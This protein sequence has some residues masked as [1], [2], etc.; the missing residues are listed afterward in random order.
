MPH[1]EGS[2]LKTVPTPHRHQSQ[3]QAS[4]T[5]EL[6]AASSQPTLWVWLIC[7]S[8]LQNREKLRFTSWLWKIITE[9][10]DAEM[11]RIS[12]V[13]SRVSFHVLPVC[14]TFQEPPRVQLSGSSSFCLFLFFYQIMYFTCR[15]SGIL[16]II[17]ISTLLVF[18]VAACIF[19]SVY[20]YQQKF[21]MK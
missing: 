2:L 1:V 7:C 5:S 13:G 15:F 10:T 4:R 8:G 14:A 9:D 17:W 21:L 3:A 12:Y 16:S 18:C 11:H 20:P 19:A 6:S